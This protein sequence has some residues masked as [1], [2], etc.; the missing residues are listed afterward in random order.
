MQLARKKQSHKNKC[1]ARTDLE[2]TISWV[3]FISLV[4]WEPAADSHQLNVW[5]GNFTGQGEVLPDA[6]ISVLC[7]QP[8]M[9]QQ[10]FLTVSIRSSIHW[11]L[12]RKSLSNKHCMYSLQHGQYP[13]EAI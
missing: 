3:T 11:V 4:W 6:Q 2:F 10:I 1:E 9:W 7:E 8:E 5:T 13:L 12:L